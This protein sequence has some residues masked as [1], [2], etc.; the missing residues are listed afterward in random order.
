MPQGQTELDPQS[1]VSLSEAGQRARGVREGITRPQQESSQEFDEKDQQLIKGLKAW[2]RA[3]GPALG[4]KVQTD[5]IVIS[6]SYQD[7][8]SI[9]GVSQFPTFSETDFEAAQTAIDQVDLLAEAVVNGK[10][11]AGDIDSFIKRYAIGQPGEINTPE[12]IRPLVESRIAEMKIK[13]EKQREQKELEKK[14]L[15]S[16]DVTGK[17]QKVVHSM[18]LTAAYLLPIFS[19]CYDTP[20]IL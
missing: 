7:L 1:L 18:T 9:A 10:I 3:S 20:K 14:I 2:A 17:L 6:A 13:R 12:R 19:T 5:D 16:W 8:C 4:G 11:E 15:N